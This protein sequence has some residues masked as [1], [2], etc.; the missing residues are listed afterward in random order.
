M[1]PIEHQELHR[2]ITDLLERGFIRESLSP[3]V[4]PALLTP[5]KDGSWRMCVDSRAINKITIKYRF[6]IPRLDD[7]LDV[8]NGA[9]IFSKVDLRSGYHQIRLRP[10]DEW[11]TAFKTRDGLFEWMVMPFGLTNAPSTFMRVMTQI[12]RPFLDKFVV[13]YFDDILIFSRNLEEHLDHL[14]QVLRTL[15][16]ESFF[17]LIS[18]S[19]LLP[20]PV[21]FSWGLLFLPRAFL[22]TS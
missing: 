20:N 7:M 14:A 1:S 19:A 10:E 4:V 21:S 3:C 16:F 2:Q 17:L 18:K 13:V 6:P 5:K 9:S 15:R 22:L 12:L 11:K 8:L